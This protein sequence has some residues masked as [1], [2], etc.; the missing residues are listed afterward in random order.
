MKPV[1][2]NQASASLLVVGHGL[3]LV[4]FCF[5]LHLTAAGCRIFS[6]EMELFYAMPDYGRLLMRTDRAMQSWWF[7]LAPLAAFAL[8]LDWRLGLRLLRSPKTPLLKFWA[9]F[10][11]VAALL[12]T[13]L[14]VGWFRW[15][16]SWLFTPSGR[17]G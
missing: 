8:W 5:A 6:D 7:L 10:V 9:H 13:A 2:D 15:W 3:S 14:C 16:M 4:F 17:L 11:F 12:N 1:G